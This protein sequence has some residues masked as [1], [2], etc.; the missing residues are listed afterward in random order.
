MLFPFPSHLWLYI[1]MYVLCVV[2]VCVV[3][4]SATDSVIK[5]RYV[6]PTSLS[7]IRFT[8]RC[9]D[10]DWW[11]ARW[12][13]LSLSLIGR[14][15]LLPRRVDPD[16]VNSYYPLPV[17]LKFSFHFCNFFLL[18]FFMCPPLLIFKWKIIL[19]SLHSEEW[20]LF[21]RSVSPSNFSNLN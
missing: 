19:F 18:V 6:S 5:Q 20:S 14:S 15:P 3:C 17:E 12:F 8:T 21:R 1:H 4:S 2:C 11:M 7:F 10:S 13:L 9:V 16:L